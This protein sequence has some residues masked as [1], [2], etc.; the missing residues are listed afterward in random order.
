MRNSEGAIGEHE[1][2]EVALMGIRVR[3][4]SEIIDD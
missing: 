3:E 2:D 4:G 1:L